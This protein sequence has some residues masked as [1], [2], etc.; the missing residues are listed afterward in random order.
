MDKRKLAVGGVIV[1]LVIAYFAFDLG[2]YFSL[3]YFKA[4]QADIDA[5]YRADPVRIG[6]VFFAIYVA[7]TG[8][9]LPGA[10]IMTLVGGAIFGLFWGTLLVSFA[11]TIGATLAFLVARYL[12]KN[13][14]QSR[15]GDSLRSVNKGVET[16]GAF[17]LFALRLV[18][19]IPFFVINVVMGLTPI[20]TLVFFVVSQIGMLPGTLVYV[21]AGTQLAEIESLADIASPSLLLSFAL[22]GIFPII[23]KKIVAIV[24]DR[25]A[26]RGWPKPARF[27]RDM[28][29]IGAGAAGLV[30]AYIAAAVRSKVTL[31]EK[32]KMGGD[33]LNYGC[34]PSK[35]SRR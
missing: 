28:V 10:A 5:A 14:V 12:L 22:L 6:L 29:V 2:Q 25:K 30:S 26:L 31:V 33:C 11:S 23:A 35:A 3:E 15:F 13:S 24:K 16:D 1:A 20:R 7:V 32:H 34:V 21:N 17:Y 19:A 18:P 8:L 27:E 4:R 9:S